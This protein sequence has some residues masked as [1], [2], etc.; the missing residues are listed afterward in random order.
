MLENGGIYIG[1]EESKIEGMDSLC[2]FNP[3]VEG[4]MFLRNFC[5]YQRVYTAPKSKRTSPF[6]P[7]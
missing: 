4:S 7:S 2:H 3:D 1:L 5:I 6:T